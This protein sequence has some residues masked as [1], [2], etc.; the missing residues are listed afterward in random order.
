M[1]GASSGSREEKAALYRVGD[2][3]I[4]HRGLVSL[5][6]IA[7]TAFMAYESMKLEMFTS[8][9]ELLPYRHPFVEIHNKYSKQF[10]GANNITIMFEVKDGTV[11]LNGRPLAEPYINDTPDYILPPLQVP[12]G[13]VFVL[14]DNRQNSYDSHSWGFLPRKNII[15]KAMFCY[16]PLSRMRMLQ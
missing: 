12:K 2:W 5:I 6:T 13:Y 14:G 9:G 15:A 8:F 11:Y 1:A 4:D 3:L 7:F 16:W 10:G